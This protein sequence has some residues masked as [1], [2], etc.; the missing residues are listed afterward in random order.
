MNLFRVILWVIVIYVAAKLIGVLVRYIRRMM[1]P[2]H[3]TIRQGP[4]EKRQF[5]DAEDVPYEEIP[6]KK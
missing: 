3:D 6:D 1:M 4:K 2:R 5:Q